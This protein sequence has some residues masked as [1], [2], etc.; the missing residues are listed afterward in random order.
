MG[1]T[2]N[3]N[4]FKKIDNER[5]AYWLGFIY[6]D[7]NIYKNMFCVHL[8]GK[9]RVHLEKFQADIQY[10]G[11]L[12]ESVSNFGTDTV[13]FQIGSK[14]LVSDLKALG[15]TERKSLTQQPLNIDKPLQKHFWR[16][17]FDGDGDVTKT[18][19]TEKQIYWRMR[20]TGNEYTLD[21]FERF[22]HTYGIEGCKRYKHGNVFRLEVTKKADVKTLATAFYHDP[23]VCLQ[24]KADAALACMSHN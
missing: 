8:A 15:L 5:S 7:G 20:L 4:F 19:R 22:L 23:E 9:D 3:R 6:A 1:Y 16:G 14:E 11:V 18:V 17:V 10:N 2:Y 12:Y 24:R 13:K 21:G